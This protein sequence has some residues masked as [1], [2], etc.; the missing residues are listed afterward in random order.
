MKGN[1][2][3]TLAVN[4]NG[5]AKKVSVFREYYLTEEQAV[6]AKDTFIKNNYNFIDTT[7]LVCHWIPL[8]K[9][10]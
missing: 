7:R 10:I 5:R 2:I 8:A 6:K 1:L 3:I 9:L 4:A